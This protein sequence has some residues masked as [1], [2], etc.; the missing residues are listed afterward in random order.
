[1][2]TLNK[3]TGWSPGSLWYTCKAYLGVQV[4]E[5]ASP[6]YG[7]TEL[8]LLAGLCAWCSVDQGSECIVYL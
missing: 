3:V 5:R 7:E 1:M 8:P 2:Q 4:S 6:V